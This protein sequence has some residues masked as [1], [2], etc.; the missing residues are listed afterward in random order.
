MADFP[1]CFDSEAEYLA[2]RKCA[3]MANEVTTICADCTPA[4]RA[5]MEAA[6]RCFPEAAATQFV[7]R[8][9]PLKRGAK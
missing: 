5:A 9:N 2:W 4:Y 7:A 8:K 3:L 1:V 6:G